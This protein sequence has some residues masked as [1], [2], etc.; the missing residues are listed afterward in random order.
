MTVVLEKHSRHL[1]FA[2]A[3]HEDSMAKAFTKEEYS[4]FRKYCRNGMHKLYAGK[5][6]DRILA[7][8]DAYF[9]PPKKKAKKPAKK[10]GNGKK[11]PAPPKEAK[12]TSNGVRE[13][14]E[15]MTVFELKSYAAHAS[16][17]IGKLRKKVDIIDSIL[18]AGAAG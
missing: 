15:T 9:A 5:Q 14:L 18:E 12:R 17:D 10:N 3:N 1:N 11:A 7:T 2:S 16:I 4:A 8:M 13:E 6:I